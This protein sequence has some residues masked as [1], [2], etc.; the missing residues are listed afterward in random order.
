MKIG[1]W[2]DVLAKEMS[3]GWGQRRERDKIQIK[4]KGLTKSWMVL[5]VSASW[6][7]SW[8]EP[9]GV[10]VADVWI[11]NR[12]FILPPVVAAISKME[13]RKQKMRFCGVRIW[14]LRHERTGLDTPMS[15]GAGNWMTEAWPLFLNL[16]YS[17]ITL[18][19]TNEK[20]LRRSC[21]SK[22]PKTEFSPIFCRKN[23]ETLKLYNQW[24]PMIMMVCLTEMSMML[25]K[26]LAYPWNHI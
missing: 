7:V 9:K 25:K 21:H 4:H 6:K 10:G 16:T 18:V 2:N 14:E 23:C 26:S 17:L 8:E 5:M 11:E 19:T 3:E 20:W 12:S 15:A 24:L 1:Y 22:A 13:V